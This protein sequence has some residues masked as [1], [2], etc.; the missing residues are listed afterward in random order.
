MIQVGKQILELEKAS[1]NFTYHNRS[2]EWAESRDKVNKIIFGVHTHHKC[3]D[4]A[5]LEPITL[6]Y[7]GRALKH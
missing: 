2:S 5:R 1:T 4:I 6:C 7:M 3:H